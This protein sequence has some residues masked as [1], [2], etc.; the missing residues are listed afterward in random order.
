[1]AEGVAAHAF[2]DSRSI[3]GELDGLL[4]SGLEYMVAT[5]RTSAWINA[6]RFRWKDILPAKLPGGIGIFLLL[7]RH[8]PRVQRDRFIPLLADRLAD[9]LGATRVTAF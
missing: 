5:L 9:G 7:C 6:Q 3:H 2:E 4:Q 8:F 1:M